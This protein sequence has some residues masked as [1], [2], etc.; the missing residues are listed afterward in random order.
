M[1]SFTVTGRALASTLATRTLRQAK[2]SFIGPARMFFRPKITKRTNVSSRLLAVRIAV[3]APMTPIAGKPNFPKIRRYASSVFVEKTTMLMYSGILVCCV[4]RRAAVQGTVMETVRKQGANRRRNLLPSSTASGISVNKR[5]T[6]SGKNVAA[7][8]KTMPI[9]R[10]NV[11]ANPR[12][13][14]IFLRSSTPQN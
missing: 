11:T 6:I 9:P 1:V 10:Q 2:N 5:R 12:T 4:E 13:F 3:A 8:K 14:L 7:I